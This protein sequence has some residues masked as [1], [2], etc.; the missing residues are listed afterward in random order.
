MH[1]EVIFKSQVIILESLHFFSY[2]LYVRLYS[3]LICIELNY[4]ALET[5]VTWDST[6]KIFLNFTYNLHQST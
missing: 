4:N 3:L 1:V 2:F 5:L 6:C